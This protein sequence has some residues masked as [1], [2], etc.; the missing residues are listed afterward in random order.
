MKRIRQDPSPGA[1]TPS[2]R[3][4]KAA[5]SKE[6]LRCGS[7]RRRSGDQ[8]QPKAGAAIRDAG[9]D[10]ADTA[11]QAASNVMSSATR[12]GSLIAEAV[13]EAA[14]RVMSG[15]WPREDRRKRPASSALIARC[16]QNRRAMRL[17][18]LGRAVAATASS[19]RAKSSSATKAA[20]RRGAIPCGSLDRRTQ[21]YARRKTSTGASKC[22]AHCNQARPST[23]KRKHLVA[24]PR[25]ESA[26]GRRGR[27]TRRRS[28]GS[29][30]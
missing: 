2:T 18:A 19:T 21:E 29:K 25:V 13:A 22:R 6:M 12:L 11:S 8:R 1:T 28:G 3:L 24:F 15:K 5:I 16:T 17:Q 30:A 14:Q 20:R 7:R 26:R 4:A 23:R 27:S 9:L 10:A